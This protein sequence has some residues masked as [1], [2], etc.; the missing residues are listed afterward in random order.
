MG[1]RKLLLRSTVLVLATTTAPTL[2]GFFGGG[3]KT[4]DAAAADV[5]SSPDFPHLHQQHSDPLPGQ[6]VNDL[7]QP[8]YG[9][10]VS[11]PIHHGK[12]SDNFAWLPHNVD[13][14]NNPTPKEYEGKPIQY[15]GDRQ[16][17]YDD[18]M[19]GCN[20]H[21]GNGR[22]Y[23]GCQITEEDRVE[24]SLRQPEGMHN[25]TEMGF[26]KMK[27]PKAVWEKVKAFWED[28]KD[29]KNWKAENWPKGNTYTNHVSW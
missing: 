11:M 4:E 16:E 25:Y 18:F 1:Q 29:Q 13:P 23:S 8:T 22:S 17:W 20:E 14:E 19:K 12:I 6:E 3:S 7:G 10:D 24:M 21:Y 5:P 9:V 15:L 27:A 28:N 2:A 26:K